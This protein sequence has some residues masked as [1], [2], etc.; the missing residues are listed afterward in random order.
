MC[1]LFAIDL[2]LPEVPRERVWVLERMA[3]ISEKD[4]LR[5]GSQK[6]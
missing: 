3:G 6:I 4:T 5:L 2:S 1:L